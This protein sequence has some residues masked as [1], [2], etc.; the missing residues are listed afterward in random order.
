M[1]ATRPPMSAAAGFKFKTENA[2]ADATT[3]WCNNQTAAQAAY[4]EINTWDT[5]TVTR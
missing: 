4:G 5:S 1:F 3:T 2:L